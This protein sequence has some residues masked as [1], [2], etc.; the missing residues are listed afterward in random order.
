MTSN[1]TSHVRVEFGMAE[2][3][4]AQATATGLLVVDSSNT[5][6]SSSFFFSFIS[7]RLH[8]HIVSQYY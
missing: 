6:S 4:T 2:G 5:S 3:G 1:P 8:H 7:L